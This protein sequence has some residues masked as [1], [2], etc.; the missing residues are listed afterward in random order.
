M[1]RIKKLT[2]LYGNFVALDSVSFNV[3]NGEILGFLGP[4]GAGK[5]TTMKIITC[6]M[7][8]TSG[9]VEVDD[10]NIYE[11]SMEIRRKIGY[12]PETNPL[13]YNMYVLDYLNFIAEIRKI[14]GAKRKERLEYVIQT[15]GLSAVLAK[16]IGT[17]SRGYRQRV[18]LAQTLIH[19]PDILILDEPTLGLDPNQIIEITD[20]IKEIGK[21]KTVM[22][23]THILPWVQSTCDRVVIINHGKIIADGSF[24]QF[25]SKY[26]NPEEVTLETVFHDLTMKNIT[27][28]NLGKAPSFGENVLFDRVHSKSNPAIPEGGE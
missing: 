28:D 23:S 7:P 4:N 12:L 20:L 26:P 21:E 10:L 22:V 13:Y 2:K 11:H 27:V 5:S 15:C 24:E 19:D 17:L 9:I 16:D 1:I 25:R 8:P 3:N 18:G 6:F 14:P